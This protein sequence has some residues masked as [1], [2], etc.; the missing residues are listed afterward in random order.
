MKPRA[1]TVT[2]KY[3]ICLSTNLGFFFLSLNFTPI[4]DMSSREDSSQ[5]L[6]ITSVQSE[7]VSDE[8]LFG[9]IQAVVPTR[10]IFC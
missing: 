9:E 2:V 3:L 4:F 1:V 8:N 6:Y 10:K 7:D 5:G